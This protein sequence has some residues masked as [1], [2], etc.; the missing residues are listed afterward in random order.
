MKENLDEHTAAKTTIKRVNLCK[1]EILKI[2][3]LKL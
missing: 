2:K 1:P 3:P